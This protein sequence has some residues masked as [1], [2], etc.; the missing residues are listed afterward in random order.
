M[1]QNAGFHLSLRLN[2]TINLLANR[3]N[4]SVFFWL[5]L[6]SNKF[7]WCILYWV[8]KPRLNRVV[9]FL[10][11]FAFS[12]SWSHHLESAQ[13]EIGFSFVPN[14]LK[15]VVHCVIRASAIALNNFWILCYNYCINYSV[16]IPAFK[17]TFTVI[18]AN[19]WI[20]S[21]IDTIYH[22]LLTIQFVWLFIFWRFAAFASFFKQIHTKCSKL[23]TKHMWHFEC[24][25]SI[26]KR[27]STHVYCFVATEH[28][29]I[30]CL[31]FF[32]FVSFFFSFIYLYALSLCLEFVFHLKVVIHFCLERNI[33]WTFS[34]SCN[35]T[36]L[37]Q[38]FSFL[39]TFT[40]I[41]AMLM[42]GPKKN[43]RQILDFQVEIEIA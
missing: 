10:L 39:I 40:W 29:T 42:W 15:F 41:S 1:Q 20:V 23:R 26:S 21:Y 34:V 25:L 16:K 8:F 3:K 14:W 37:F 5:F 6:P 22:N 4:G 38:L 11:I 27:S 2:E 31:A 28:N 36:L 7:E 33:F 9:C 19:S 35:P 43:R 32:G 13:I 17:S 24:S 18:G 12:S 30:E